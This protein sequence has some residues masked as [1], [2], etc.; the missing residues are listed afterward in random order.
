MAAVTVWQLLMAVVTV[1]QLLTAMSLL[2]CSLQV[3]FDKLKLVPP[4]DAKA[5]K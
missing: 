4:P 1:R 3:L 5:L 2:W